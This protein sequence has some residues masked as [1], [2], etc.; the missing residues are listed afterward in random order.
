MSE[1][2]P[3]LAPTNGRP[4]PG[5]RVT[6][7][8]LRTQGVVDH[9]EYWWNS[10]MFPVILDG[11]PRITQMLSPS[12]VICVPGTVRHLADYTSNSATPPRSP[13]TS[14]DTS[15]KTT[16]TRNRRTGAA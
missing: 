1:P 5:T 3:S 16:S 2:N 15:S 8:S 6:I 9:Y 7:P 13:A 4:W 12:Q 10:R 11:R 14:P